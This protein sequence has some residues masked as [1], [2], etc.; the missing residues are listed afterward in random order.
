MIEHIL[1]KWRTR[2]ARHREQLERCSTGEHQP[3]KR[4]EPWARGIC[5]V[6]GHDTLVS[7]ISHGI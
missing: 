6:C 2:Q 5:L 3:L 1:T 7:E 4:A